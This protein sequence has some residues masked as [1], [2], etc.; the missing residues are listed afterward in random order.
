MNWWSTGRGG[1]KTQRN[2]GEL[3]T[4]DGDLETGNKTVKAGMAPSEHNER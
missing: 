1:R 4:A 3:E 2:E